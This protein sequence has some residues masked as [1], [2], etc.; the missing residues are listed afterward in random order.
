M[1]G[2]VECQAQRQILECLS[3]MLGVAVPER[4]NQK[5][6]QILVDALRGKLLDLNNRDRILRLQN[7]LR[8]NGR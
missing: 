3:E 8:R 5:N 4:W 2:Q 1:D 7:D 6:G